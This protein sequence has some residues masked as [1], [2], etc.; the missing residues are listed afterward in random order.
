MYFFCFIFLSGWLCLTTS[1][2]QK[3]L[4]YDCISVA[5]EFQILR[6]PNFAW[7]GWNAESHEY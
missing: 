1:N 5:P 7:W 6:M 3:M 2:K 4:Y